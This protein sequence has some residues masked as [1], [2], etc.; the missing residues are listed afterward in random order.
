MNSKRLQ[1]DK[2]KEGLSTLTNDIQ[3]DSLWNVISMAWFDR[4]R[5]Y[6]DDTV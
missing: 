5:L 3:V 6:V 1:R 2:V 4:W